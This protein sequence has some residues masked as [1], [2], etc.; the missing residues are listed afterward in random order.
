MLESQ[1]DTGSEVMIYE[2]LVCGTKLKK[3]NG[4][5]QCR[6]CGREFIV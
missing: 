6:N 3:I 5:M 1:N 2:C 4:I